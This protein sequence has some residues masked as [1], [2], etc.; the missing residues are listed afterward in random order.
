MDAYYNM[1]GNKTKLS[2]KIKD[3]LVL[4]GLEI[5]S[6]R[7]VFDLIA[8]HE[9]LN[10]FPHYDTTLAVLEKTIE[11]ETGG[12]LFDFIKILGERD[13]IKLDGRIMERIKGV[14]EMEAEVLKE[15]QEQLEKHLGKIHKRFENQGDN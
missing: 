5:D 9:M 10:Y 2:Q 6:A 3:R 15:R 12:E 7:S 11:E 4:K 13:L 1:I 8:Y 14:P